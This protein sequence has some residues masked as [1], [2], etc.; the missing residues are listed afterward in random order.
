MCLNW[1]GLLPCQAVTGLIPGSNTYAIGG[2]NGPPKQLNTN[3]APVVTGMSR[4]RNSRC[5][6]LLHWTKQEQI[7]F[8]E[9]NHVYIMW[10]L[11][12]IHDNSLNVLDFLGAARKVVSISENRQSKSKSN[13]TLE[14][15][16]M[17]VKVK[18][19]RRC[20]STSSGHCNTCKIICYN[21]TDF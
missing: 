1:G 10:A 21:D 11:Q 3:Q 8:M 12:Y 17:E 4:A 9:V 16:Y 18:L 19:S 7:T 2:Q 14:T 20:T 13:M 15:G 6:M 5:G